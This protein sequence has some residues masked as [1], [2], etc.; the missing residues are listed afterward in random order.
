MSLVTTAALVDNENDNNNNNIINRK[1]QP[2]THNKTQRRAGADGFNSAKVNNVLASIHNKPDDDD[3]NGSVY[4]PYAP[5]NPLAPPTSVGSTERLKVKGDE[6]EGMHNLVPKPAD[7]DDFELQ[8]LQRNFM[9]ETEA[10]AYYKRIGVNTSHPRNQ[11][12]KSYYQPTQ[13]SPIEQG[14]NQVLIDKLNYMINLLEE[15]QDQKTNTATEDV[16]LYSFL[17]VFIIFIA[18]SFA[19]VGKYTR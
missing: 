7:T 2:T 17:G 5:L 18:D 6:K 15:Q 14:S 13:Q 11:H 16:I 4:Q 3:D 19:R 1:R 9:T 12:N 8:E 10:Q